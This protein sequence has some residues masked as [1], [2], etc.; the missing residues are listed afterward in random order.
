MFS[1][2][3]FVRLYKLMRG[4]CLNVE[5]SIHLEFA[6]VESVQRLSGRQVKDPTVRVATRVDCLD[7]VSCLMCVNS[8]HNVQTYIERRRTQN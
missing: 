7:A 5:G 4:I 2:L 8:H 6:P 3:G 1:Y